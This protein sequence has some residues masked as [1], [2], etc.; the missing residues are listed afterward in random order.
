MLGS[1]GLGIMV[2]FFLNLAS[3]QKILLS[4]L[5][6]FYIHIHPP[7]TIPSKGYYKRQVHYDG[8]TR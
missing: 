8:R 4:F 2:L 7:Y 6:T 3:H 1:I 5:E